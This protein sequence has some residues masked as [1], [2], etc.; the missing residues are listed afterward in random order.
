MVYFSM[1]IS[2]P[3]AVAYLLDTHGRDTPYILALI[4][5]MK[6]H[7]SLMDLHSFVNGMEV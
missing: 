4:K 2:G 3:A 7:G 1:V 5:F 6:E